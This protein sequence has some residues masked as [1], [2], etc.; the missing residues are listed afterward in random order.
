MQ[1]STSN[2]GAPSAAAI[3]TIRRPAA[4]VV[5]AVEAES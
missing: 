1:P 5:G 3:P 4:V 2:L